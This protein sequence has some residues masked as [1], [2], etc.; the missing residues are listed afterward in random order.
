[1]PTTTQSDKTSGASPGQSDK[2]DR[3]LRIYD[4]LD[5]GGKRELLR[6]GMALLRSK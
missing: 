3:L 6:F 4:E 5:D 1:M 2:R